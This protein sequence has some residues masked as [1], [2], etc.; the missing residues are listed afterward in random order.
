LIPAGSDPKLIIVN[1]PWHIGATG[2][3][4]AYDAWITVK[5]PKGVPFN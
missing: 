2:G 1:V 5:G 3:V 4:V